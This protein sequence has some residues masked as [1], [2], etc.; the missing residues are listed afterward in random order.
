MSVIWTLDGWCGWPSTVTL[1]G[2]PT[3][4]TPCTLDGWVTPFTGSLPGLGGLSGGG[5]GGFHKRRF[6]RPPIKRLDDILK[7]LGAPE[8]YEELAATDKRDEAATIVRVHAKSEAA[9]PQLAV[10]DW[11]ALANDAKATGALMALWHRHQ[12]ELDDEDFWRL[13]GG[14]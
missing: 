7:N 9:V 11:N 4:A 10:V 13:E 6:K 5:G 14:D 3:Q 2:W 1:D 12:I 8:V